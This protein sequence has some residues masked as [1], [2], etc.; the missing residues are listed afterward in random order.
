MD[1]GEIRGS[2]V[3]A[4]TIAAVLQERMRGDLGKNRG[5]NKNREGKTAATAAEFLFLTSHLSM[6][7]SHSTQGGSLAIVATMD[8]GGRTSIGLLATILPRVSATSFD[9]VS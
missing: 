8:T 1:R 9:S 3:R 7:P 6:G 4:Y 2:G 5:G